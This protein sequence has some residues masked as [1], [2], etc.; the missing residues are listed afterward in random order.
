[1]PHFQQLNLHKAEQ[2]TVL[3]AGGLA[4]KT[5]QVLLVT[6]PYS[7]AG[8]IVGMPSG[9]RTVQFHD[10]NAKPQPPRAGIISTADIQ[11]RPL[12]AHC[13]RDCAVA[14]ARL[15]DTDTL[16]ISAY[17]DIKMPVVQPWLP[18]LLR[19]AAGRRWAVILAMDT[20]AHSPMFGVDSNQR[21]DE[22]E[23]S[24]CSTVLR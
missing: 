18:A 23:D 14:L 22:L 17:L 13:T 4:G 16:I 19:L 10:T 15:H 9:R 1:M 3:L 8:K 24:Y 11:L 5:N 2:A 20:N 6:E 21:G 7:V 12:E